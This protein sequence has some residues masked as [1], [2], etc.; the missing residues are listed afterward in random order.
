[1]WN[2]LYV[3]FDPYNFKVA[4]VFLKNSAPL[5]LFTVSHIPSSLF[6]HFAEMNTVKIIAIS[7]NMLPSDR[8]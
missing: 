3:T 8:R 5:L 1:V 4:P 6:Q 7:K 2:L